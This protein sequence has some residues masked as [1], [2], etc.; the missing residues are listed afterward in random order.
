MSKVSTKGK[1]KALPAVTEPDTDMIG[2]VEIVEEIPQ[3]F[4]VPPGIGESSKSPPTK[5][6]PSE[7]ASSKSAPKLTS[8]P[9]AATKAECPP[10]LRPIVEAEQRR[11]AETAA[12]LALCSA[13]ISGVEATLLP[14]TNGSNRQFVDS[15]R[16]YLRVAIAQYMA[17]CSASTPP[18]LPPRPANPFSKAPDARSTPTPAVPALSIKSTW[19]K[20]AKN[21]LRR[22]AVPIAKAVPLSAAKAQ[23][24]ETP[25]AKVDKRLFLRLEKDHPWRKLPTSCVTSK[26]ENRFFFFHDKI[27]SLHRVRTGFAILA[28][29][30]KTRQEM[31]D[32]SSKLA[33]ENVKLEASSDLVA[34][35]IPNVPVSIVRERGPVVVDSEWVF[36]KNALTTGARPIHVRPHGTCRPGA[37]HRNWHALFD[38]EVAPRAGF[39]LFDESGKATI[40]K[41]RRQIEQCKRCLSFHATRGCSRA[42]ACWNCGST[43]HSD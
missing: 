32:G 5:S 7:N 18:V 21:G 1:E 34:L 11:A 31:L 12:N 4:S 33:S 36:D 24:K 42:P 43:M 3:P 17:T 26:L 10:E 14:L 35:H 39:R 23:K 20:V 2:S 28:N 30:K 13:A 37:P 9:I 27:T 15:M 22:K 40:H 16:V 41:P 19:A 38:R 6:K 29:N 8:Q 25:K